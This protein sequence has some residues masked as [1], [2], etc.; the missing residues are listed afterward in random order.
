MP[1]KHPFRA[2]AVG[3]MLA[4]GASS[5]LMAQNPTSSRRTKILERLPALVQENEPVA[6]E[7]VTVTP[8]Q[9]TAIIQ[10]TAGV[11]PAKTSTAKSSS[12]KSAAPKGM[13]PVASKAAAKTSQSGKATVQTAKKNQA[14]VK[15]SDFQGVP[16]PAAVPGV[17]GATTT[18][19][20]STMG[21]PAGSSTGRPYKTTPTDVKA[22]GP[23]LKQRVQYHRDKFK[24]RWDHYYKPGLQETHWGY[25]E[26]FCEKP[27]GYYTSANFKTMVANGEASRMVLHEMDF[28]RGEARLNERGREQLAKMAHMLP[29]NFFPLIIAQSGDDMTLADARRTAILGLLNE[30]GFAVPEQRI[31]LATPLSRGLVGTEGEIIANT[32]FGSFEAG[33]VNYGFYS[34]YP[35]LDVGSYGTSGTGGGTT[36]S[37]V[38][39]GQGR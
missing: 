13:V 15:S 20:T 7:T 24:Y 28:V 32:Y 30:S 8:A 21:T 2:I 5:T 12:A 17:P 11:A 26:E 29:R 16:E 19:V 39:A 9:E 4:A 3:L 27:L 37:A 34:V 25:P 22:Q 14:E 36:N 6:A 38:S 10:Q 18:T 23:Y 31:V 33:G 1:I 35:D